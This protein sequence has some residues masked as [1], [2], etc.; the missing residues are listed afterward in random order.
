[1]HGNQTWYV[2]NFRF[3]VLSGRIVMDI[4]TETIYLVSVAIEQSIAWCRKAENDSAPILF[5]QQIFN[6]WISH[7]RNGLWGR[8]LSLG[9]NLL[10]Q[11]TFYKFFLGGEDVYTLGV[12]IIM[13]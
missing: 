11:Q 5:I 2:Y 4:Y 8:F 12:C 7:T 3:L 1:M 6:N 10:L 13:F 9:L